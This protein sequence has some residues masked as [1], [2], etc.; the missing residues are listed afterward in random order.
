[1][2]V[3]VCKMLWPAV[4]PEAWKNWNLPADKAR[5]I[6]EREGWH[7][8]QRHKE[9][10]SADTNLV[11]YCSILS[12]CERGCRILGLKHRV[13]QLYLMSLSERTIASMK[14]DTAATWPVLH[15]LHLDE[16]NC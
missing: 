12:A 7:A 8:K 5:V 13:A 2:F 6:C 4:K 15:P 14:H 11:S 3:A 10:L 9:L 1:M 16:E